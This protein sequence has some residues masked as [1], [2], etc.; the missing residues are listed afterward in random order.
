M[1]AGAV[2]ELTDADFEK[3]IADAET[4]VLV[5]FWATWCAPCRCVAPIVEEIASEFGEKLI[6][7]KVDVDSNEQVTLKHD[8]KSIPTLMIFKG[9]EVKERLVGAHPKQTLIDTINRFV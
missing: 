4:P 5:D 8:I 2:I 1:A 6:V 3:T 9:G 7:G